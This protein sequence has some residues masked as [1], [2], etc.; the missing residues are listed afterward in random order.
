MGYLLVFLMVVLNDGFA[1]WC[2]IDSSLIIKDKSTATLK[3]LITSALNNDLAS[4]S[5]GVCGVRIKFDHKFIGDLTIDLISPAGQKVR[6]IGPLG[7]SGISSFSKWS[8]TLFH[9]DCRQFLIPVLKNV[10][11][12]NNPGEF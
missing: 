7:N 3:L 1:Q 10:G 4:Q 9:V 12:T 2:C 6:L 8:V 5:Q 11:I